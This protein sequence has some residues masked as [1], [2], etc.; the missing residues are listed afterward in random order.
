MGA[1]YP[2]LT[3]L[4]RVVMWQEELG[5][6]RRLTMH[7]DRIIVALSLTC[8][9]VGP[10]LLAQNPLTVTA[11]DGGSVVTKLG[12]GISVNQGSS[13][14]R[15]WFVVNDSTCPL[16]LQNAGINT[17]YGD[18]DYSFVPAG[19]AIAQEPIAALEVRFILFDIWGDHMKTLS[20]T[21]IRDLAAGATIKL[22]QV[23][24]WRA[25]EN[26]V[27]HYVTAVAFV[28]RVRAQ[29]GRA[30]GANTQAILREVEA[31]KLKATQELLMPSK[32]RE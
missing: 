14:K 15:Q 13:L 7:Q 24:S 26:D 30:W 18:R 32:P 28:A 31:A 20:G 12:Y 23:G 17:T 25:W 29:N 10:A 5:S 9:L 1:W 21:D 22:T 19:T 6:G 4:Q 3:L 8:V 16:Q 27:S 11:V 2:F